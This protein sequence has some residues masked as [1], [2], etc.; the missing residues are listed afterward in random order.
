MR[1]RRCRRSDRTDWDYVRF[2]PR[3]PANLTPT[4]FSQ[5]VD[6]QPPDMQLIDPAA[7]QSRLFHGEASDG[8]RPD[9]QCAQCE[10]ADRSAPMAAAPSARTGGRR[11]PVVRA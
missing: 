10:R 7:A 4:P 8:Q 1:L 2:D 11:W 6:D 3:D 5:P 9:R